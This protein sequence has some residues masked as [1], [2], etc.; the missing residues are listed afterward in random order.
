MKNTNNTDNI[1]EHSFTALT[2]HLPNQFKEWLIANGFLNI[3]QAIAITAGPGTGKSSFVLHWAAHLVLGK[4]FL[5]FKSHGPLTVLYIQ[6]EDTEDDLANVVRGIIEQ[7]K[8]SP[9]ELAMLEDNL[10][11]RTVIAVSGDKFIEQLEYA[12]S[13]TQPDLV[14]TDP[15]FAFIGADAANQV[16][17][18]QFLRGGMAPLLRKYN[19]GWICVHHNKRERAG[20]GGSRAFGSIE[21]PAFFRGMIELSPL[22]DGTV[23]L[24]VV[25]RSRQADLRDQT[26]LPTS[27]LYLTKGT[28][29]I[30]WHIGAPRVAPRAKANG[31][32]A[33][34]PRASGRPSNIPPEEAAA[35]VAKMRAAKN[36]NAEIVA[37][38]ARH[39]GTSPRNARRHL[40]PQEGE[41][42]PS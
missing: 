36:T 24:D 23:K 38:I 8:P 28:S 11:L 20:D 40:P 16:P 2:K 3:G 13:D 1:V 18:T 31:S 4:P 9:D 22:K 27:T 30:T 32:A 41:T 35:L 34:V 14:I 7:L 12:L 15:L 39:F 42:S 10:I 37:E 29:H 19:C 17:V 6:N 25:K 26:G 21:I 33:G 5:G